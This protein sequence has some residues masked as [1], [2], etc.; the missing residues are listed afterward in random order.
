MTESKNGQKKKAPRATLE[1]MKA[2]YEMPDVVPAEKCKIVSLLEDKDG[3]TWV[4][5]D[6]TNEY[7]VNAYAVRLKTKG[8]TIKMLLRAEAAGVPAPPLEEG[9]LPVI[10][11]DQ[12]LEEQKQ[13]WPKDLLGKGQ[14]TVRLPFRPDNI[15]IVDSLD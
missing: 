1:E 11:R 13:K 5:F 2:L 10:S 4:F 7:F 15:E 12:W 6:A 14:D 9:D 3:N 8:Q